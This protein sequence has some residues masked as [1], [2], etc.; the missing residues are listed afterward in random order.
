[1]QRNVQVQCGIY[2]LLLVQPNGLNNE[3][4]TFHWSRKYCSGQSDC[5]TRLAWIQPVLSPKPDFRS[6]GMSAKAEFAVCEELSSSLCVGEETVNGKIRWP[7]VDRDN[8]SRS[9]QTDYP[10]A[11][12]LSAQSN[13]FVPRVQGLGWW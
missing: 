8:G 9:K 6:S 11:H 5:A 4:R 3:E 12:V 7:L 13:R 10:L 1:M 2:P